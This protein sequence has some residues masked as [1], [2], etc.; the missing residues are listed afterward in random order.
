MM[1]TTAGETRPGTEIL[2]AH[3]D[4]VSWG[5]VLQ[6]ISQW[7]AGRESRYVCVCSVH[8][9]VTAK[10]DNSFNSI[11]NKADLSTADGMPLVWMLRTRGFRGQ[12]RIYG[13]DLMW[14]Y[15]ERTAKTGHSVYLYGSSAGVLDRLQARLH[16]AFPALKIAGAYSPPFREMSEEEDRR[17]VDEINRSG[18]GVVFVGLGCPK[19]ERWMA[20][21]RGRIQATMIGV[22]AAFDFHAGTL[23]Q[24]PRWIQRAGLEWLY[25]LMTE[26]RRLWRRYLYNNSFFVYY[27]IREMLRG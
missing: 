4:A 1:T 12:Q 23:R 9:L 22:G 10:Q 27:L 18:A 15:C 11:I 3:I 8:S 26:P 19:Q 21:H 20:A 6:T 14:K 16:E 2:G 17:I 13:P 7:A 24:A 25:R 5:D